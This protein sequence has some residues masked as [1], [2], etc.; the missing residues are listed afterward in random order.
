MPTAMIVAIIGAEGSRQESSVSS[1]SP[2]AEWWKSRISPT[3]SLM[4]IALN[5]TGPRWLSRIIILGLNVSSIAAHD[6]LRMHHPRRH[7]PTVRPTAVGL[8]GALYHPG[9]HRPHAGWLLH[10]HY[11]LH[12]AS[13]RLETRPARQ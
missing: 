6:L 10:L 3:L 2:T 7:R 1:K 13:L 12:Q 11:A 9:Q 8:D 4:V 5:S